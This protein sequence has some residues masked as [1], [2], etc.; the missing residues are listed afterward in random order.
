MTVSPVSP[1]RE[2][3]LIVHANE[4]YLIHMADQCPEDWH[5]SDDCSALHLMGARRRGGKEMG[6]IYEEELGGGSA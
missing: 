3:W 5:S 6:R 4:K 1:L 2:S